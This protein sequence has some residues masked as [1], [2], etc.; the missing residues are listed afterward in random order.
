MTFFKTFFFFRFSKLSFD[1]YRSSSFIVLC[2]PTIHFCAFFLIKDTS[3]GE[4]NIF[5]FIFFIDTMV[6]IFTFW[7]FARCL[8]WLWLQL[9]IVTVPDLQSL[10]RTGPSCSWIL[11]VRIFKEIEK[12]LFNDP[13]TLLVEKMRRWISKEFLTTILD[14]C[15]KY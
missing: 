13:V 11:A 8:I 7:T 9:D 1:T 14:T 12:S 4:G 3:K 5:L 6:L 2:Y 15:W 10:G